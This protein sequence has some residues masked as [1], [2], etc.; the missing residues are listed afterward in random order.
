MSS[1]GCFA[2]VGLMFASPSVDESGV[3][4]DRHLIS[5]DF[6]SGRALRERGADGSPRGAFRAPTRTV[7]GR[8]AGKGWCSRSYSADGHQAQEL[9]DSSEPRPPMPKVPPH[10]VAPR[11]PRMHHG[12]PGLCTECPPFSPRVSLPATAHLPS[13]DRDPANKALMSLWPPTSP[14]LS[15]LSNGA[16]R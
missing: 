4:S 13:H 6:S 8:A 1:L 7:G 15:F 3:P 14:N 12:L 2:T 10:P 5:E 16:P 11:S 9:T